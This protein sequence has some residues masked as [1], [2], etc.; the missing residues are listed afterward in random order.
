[1]ARSQNTFRKKEREKKK[2]Q[3]RKGKEEKKALKKENAKSGSLDNM[4]AY[5]DINGNFSDAPPKEGD[6]TMEVD[7]S[8]I[9]VST[10]KSVAMELDAERRG[11]VKFFNESKGFGFIVPQGGQEQYFFHESNVKGNIQERDKVKFKLEK[12]EKGL[13]AVD[14]SKI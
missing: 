1:M 13:N 4:I 12:G 11:L 9:D 14:V 5:V 6:D 2:Q 10:P 3:K 8:Q 7:A